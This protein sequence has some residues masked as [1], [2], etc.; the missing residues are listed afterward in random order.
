MYAASFDS[1]EY[2]A[3]M[4]NPNQYQTTSKTS[5]KLQF[6][7]ERV[8]VVGYVQLLAALVMTIVLVVGFFAEGE[9]APV[10]LTGLPLIFLNA[11]AGY[12][13]ITSQVKWYFLSILN[14]ALQVVSVQ[15]GAFAYTYTGMGAINLGI[16][17]DL[18][19]ET[20]VGFGLLLS[21]T[22][23]LEMKASTMKLSVVEVDLVAV[24]FVIAIFTAMR[25]R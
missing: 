11:I 22:F 13:A 10:T 14:Q 2:S 21:S 18:I 4:Q 1:D 9:S 8:K 20:Q 16:N 17:R 23:E 6:I 5:R 3:F 25:R 12:T 24:S 7:K 15:L 19:G